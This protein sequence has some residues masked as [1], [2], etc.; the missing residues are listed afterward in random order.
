MFKY[1]YSMEP[2]M[3]SHIE[4][5]FLS[6]STRW[7]YNWNTIVFEWKTDDCWA[8]TKMTMSS[9][10]MGDDLQAMHLPDSEGQHRGKFR[11][12]PIRPCGLGSPSLHGAELPEEP[13]LPAP[14]PAVINN[15]SHCV[16]GPEL[17]NTTT[18]DYITFLSATIGL[19]FFFFFNL[20]YFSQ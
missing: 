15:T 20:F 19:M 9:S 6:Q 3:L 1:T 10:L 16:P 5:H 14:L 17:R 4:T 13:G 18:M 2:L 8:G 11:W 12:F 7:E